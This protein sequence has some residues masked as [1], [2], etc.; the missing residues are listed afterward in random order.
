M[1]N[2]ATCQSFDTSAPA[3]YVQQLRTGSCPTAI[4]SLICLHCT[5]RPVR[6]DF[7][8]EGGGMSLTSR[9]G[10]WNRRSAKYG[11]GLGECRHLHNTP[12]AGRAEHGSG[13]IRC[14]Q[15]IAGGQ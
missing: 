11:H 3:N 12:C 6:N 14:D 13:H 1:S 5:C 15:I 4:H 10:E 7:A 8:S 2:R 9:I